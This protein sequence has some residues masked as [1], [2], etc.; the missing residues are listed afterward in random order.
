M[1]IAENRLVAMLSRTWW[2]LLLRGLVAIAFGV[3]TAASAQQIFKYRTPDGRIVYSD[4]QV[5]NATLVEEFEG[6]PAPDPATVAARKEAERA[7]AK[8]VND[9]AAERV[10][11]IDAVS[12]EIQAASAA[13]A[14]AQAA[15]EVGRE[16]LEGERIGTYA[17]RARLSDAYWARQDRN[18]QAVAEAQARLDRA[19]N[20]MNQIR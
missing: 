4:K 3:A 13:L 15:L 1:N 19:Q 14:Q 2:V 10:K 12:A 18:E 17:H 20:A 11:A 16:P 5:P 6:A 9:I 7:K 8:A